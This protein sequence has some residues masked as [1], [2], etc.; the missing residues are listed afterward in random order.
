MR[1][2]ISYKQQGAP[3]NTAA[4]NLTDVSGNLEVEMLEI[5]RRHAFLDAQDLDTD[6]LVVDIEIQNDTRLNL[7]GFDDL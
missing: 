5:G 2:I 7:L 1:S 4:I 6:N 3:K